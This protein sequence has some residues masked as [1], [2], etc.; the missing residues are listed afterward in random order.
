VSNLRSRVTFALV[1]AIGHACAPATPRGRVPVAVVH[2]TASDPQGAACQRRFPSDGE[3]RA[4]KGGEAIGIDE[5][6]ASRPRSGLFTVEGFVQV[7]HSC[8]RCPEGAVCK[9]CESTVWLSP[10]R[11]AY[12]GPLTFDHDLLIQVPDGTRFALLARYRMTV[13]VCR[14]RAPGRPLGD[15]E[16]RGYERLDN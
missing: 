3:L 14:R 13:E 10:A 11:G 16:L 8:P 4:V 1:A 7:V 15:L 2:P 5:L 12:K 6:I 9:P